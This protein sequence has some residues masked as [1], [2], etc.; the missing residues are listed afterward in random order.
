MDDNQKE[1]IKNVYVEKGVIIRLV[2]DKSKANILIEREITTYRNNFSID[3]SYTL[4]I[5]KGLN[6][7]SGGFKYY[8]KALELVKD[9]KNFKL[10]K[11][12][13]PLIAKSFN[14]TT[15]AV[16]RALQNILRRTNYK[17]LGPKSFIIMCLNE[18]S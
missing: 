4:L 3:R 9:N 10:E 8:Q 13:Y 7:R 14:T 11:D 2:E 12:V 18:L 6:Q 17:G 1:V 15:M 5:S 16:S